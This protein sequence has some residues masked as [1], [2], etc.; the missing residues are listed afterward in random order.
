[1]AG[2]ALEEE[3]RPAAPEEGDPR[4]QRLQAALNTCVAGWETMAQ[5]PLTL[6]SCST[7]GAGWG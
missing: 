7:C 2:A 1:M 3:G 6:L 5:R 4:R